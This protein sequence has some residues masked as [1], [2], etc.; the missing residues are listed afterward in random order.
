MCND[1]IFCE[2]NNY[3]NYYFSEKMTRKGSMCVSKSI[4]FDNAIVVGCQ[5]RE[6]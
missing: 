3:E 1:S 5:N 2:E 4:F 6:N